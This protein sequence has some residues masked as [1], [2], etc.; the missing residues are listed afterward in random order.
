MPRIVGLVEHTE[1]SVEAQQWLMEQEEEVSH[2]DGK[3]LHLT[4]HSLFLFL[5]LSESHPRMKLK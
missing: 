2:E 5:L 3:C 1:T 4:P